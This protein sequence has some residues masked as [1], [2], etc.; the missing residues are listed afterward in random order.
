MKSYGWIEQ[1]PTCHISPI[2]AKLAEILHKHPKSICHKG[3]DK[4][5]PPPGDSP[6]RLGRSLQSRTSTAAS[7]DVIMVS[8]V[9]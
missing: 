4:F 5:M 8:F 3:A 6:V 1:V 2:S 9:G 7:T